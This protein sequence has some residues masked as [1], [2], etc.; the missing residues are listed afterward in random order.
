MPRSATLESLLRQHD[1]PRRSDDSRSST[2][3]AAC[4]IRASSAPI[5]PTRSPARSTACSASSG[6]RSTP[7]ACCASSCAA[8]RRE[9]RAAFDVEVVPLPKDVRDSTPS[10]IEISTDDAVAGRRVRRGGR[11]HPAAAAAG[12]DL[13]RRDRLQRRPAAAAIASKCCSTARP[14]HGEFVGYGDVR[15]AVIVDGRPPRHRDPFRRSPTARRT[16]TTSRAGRC[17]VS[18]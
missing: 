12:R 11:E 14:A 10:S 8:R 6:I 3:S 16:G 7:T 17:S 15:A 5:R 4:S 13:R 2:P 18:S 9:W 1:L